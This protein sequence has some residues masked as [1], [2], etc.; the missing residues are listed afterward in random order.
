MAYF[1]EIDPEVDDFAGMIAEMVATKDGP[2]DGDEPPEEFMAGW[3]DMT[4]G[5]KADALGM[6]KHPSTG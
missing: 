6:D 5:E 2:S 3:N 1:D 4:E